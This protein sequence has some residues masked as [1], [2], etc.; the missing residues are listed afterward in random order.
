ML[1][2]LPSR[3]MAVN[4]HDRY[5]EKQNYYK[6]NERPNPTIKTN[7]DG[8]IEKKCDYGESDDPPRFVDR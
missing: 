1:V 5:E 3:Q 4:G 8:R 6:I 7:R 2:N